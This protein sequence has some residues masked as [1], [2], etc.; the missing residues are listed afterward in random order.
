MNVLGIIAACII[1]I[2]NIYVL[3]VS[4]IIQGF[5]VGNNM[6]I[7]PIYIHELTPKDILG[8]FGVATQFYVVFAVVFCYTLGVIF[9]VTDLNG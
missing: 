7:I 3:L 2:N 8:S 6:A 5:V 1:Q 4:R 9:Y